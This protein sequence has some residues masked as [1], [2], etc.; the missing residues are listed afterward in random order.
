MSVPMHLTEDGLPVGVQFMAA[1]GRE[2][3]LYKMAGIL[4]QSDHWLD[5]KANPIFSS[6]IPENS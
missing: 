1:I 3:Q 4:E 5:I 6:K 2:D